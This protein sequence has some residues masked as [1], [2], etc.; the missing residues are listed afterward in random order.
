[1][2]GIFYMDFFTAINKPR[3]R[4]YVRPL[5]GMM[6]VGDVYYTLDPWKNYLHDKRVYRPVGLKTFEEMNKRISSGLILVERS[7]YEVRKAEMEADSR[8]INNS[9]V[10]LQLFE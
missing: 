9:Y 7:Y 6:N 8:T 5:L 1:M 4:R 2:L 3:T 10:Q